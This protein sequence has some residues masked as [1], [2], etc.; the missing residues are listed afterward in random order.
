MQSI[1][2]SFT[3]R[4]SPLYSK[5]KIK[6]DIFEKCGIIIPASKLYGSA[7]FI[8]GREESPSITGQG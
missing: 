6:L 4:T 5:S 1:G 8:K 3:Y 7:A 2:P